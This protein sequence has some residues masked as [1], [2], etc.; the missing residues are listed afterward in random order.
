MDGVRQ[1][2]LTGA[3]PALCREDVLGISSDPCLLDLPDGLFFS[4][5]TWAR[6]AGEKDLSW[7]AYCLYIRAPWQLQLLLSLGG[8]RHSPFYILGSQPLS[9]FL[10]LICNTWSG[11]LPRL[12]VRS[13]S[14]SGDQRGC[15]N[16]GSSSVEPPSVQT[17]TPW[18][19]YMYACVYWGMK[20]DSWRFQKGASWV[21]RGCLWGLSYV[22]SWR[23]F[24]DEVNVL[25]WEL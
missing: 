2:R 4:V 7:L 17:P 14:F 13:D 3:R 9:P 1:G 24:L 21:S 20:G 16:Q 8:G 11:S 5:L 19:V 22:S 25:I 10:K 6:K 15:W 18:P 12:S 23:V